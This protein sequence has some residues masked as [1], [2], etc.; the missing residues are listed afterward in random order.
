MRKI[1]LLFLFALL[2]APWAVAQTVHVRS[3]VRRDGTVVHSYNRRAPGSKESEGASENSTINNETT[4]SPNFR[5][6]PEEIER[7]V[8]EWEAE[9]SFSEH[10]PNTDKNV[11]I[12][13][14]YLQKHG[15]YVTVSGM[16]DAIRS[17]HKKLDWIDADPLDQSKKGR[18]KRSTAAKDAFKHQQPCPSTGESSGPCPGYVIDH[19]NPLACGGA[20]DPSNMQWQTIAD[21]KAKDKI[22]RIGCE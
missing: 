9:S 4:T 15:G 5:Q 17:S 12:M 10:L 21:G 13:I 16:D 2:I 6:S 19:V 8:K 7:V 14:R 22:E 3:Y 1:L 20:D 11:A 18:I